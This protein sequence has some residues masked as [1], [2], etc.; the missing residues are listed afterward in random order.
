MRVEHVKGGSRSCVFELS[1]RADAIA[2][3]GIPSFAWLFRGFGEPEVAI[4]KHLEPV[5][6]V[7]YCR[8]LSRVNTIVAAGSHVSVVIQFQNI[9]Q[10]MLESLLGAHDI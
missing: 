7:Y 2:A 8:V 10:L 3:G 4:L 6:P 5:F 9:I 1:P